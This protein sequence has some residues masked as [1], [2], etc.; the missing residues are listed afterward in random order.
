[1]TG[2]RGWIYTTSRDM[3]FRNSGSKSLSL[4]ECRVYHGLSLELQYEDDDQH[5]P[6]LVPG[7]MFAWNQ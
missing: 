6:P 3:T 2:P 1:M 7:G 4:T 5:E